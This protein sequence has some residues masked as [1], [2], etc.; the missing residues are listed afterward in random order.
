MKVV[1]IREVWSGQ[2]IDL[3]YEVLRAGLPRETAMF[4]HDRDPSTRHFA[5]YLPGESGKLKD[6]GKLVCCA[7]FTLGDWRGFK[8][9][10]LRGMATD[11]EYQ[12]KGIGRQLLT[13]AEIELSQ[14]SINMLWCKARKSAI[15]FYEKL[16]WATCSAEFEIPTAGPHIEMFKQLPRVQKC[17]WFA[18]TTLGGN[19]SNWTHCEDCT[20]GMSE[21]N[22][23]G[24]VE[25]LTSH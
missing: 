14:P 10:A 19:C 11:P 5:A 8:S 22:A 2:I 12:G 6:L 21:C 4:D 18:R 25:G 20:I 9:F 16:G 15:G 3:R 17:D 13:R 24:T 7:T 23:C 1:R